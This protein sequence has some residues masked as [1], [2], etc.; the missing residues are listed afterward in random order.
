MFFWPF[1]DQWCVFFLEFNEQIP[2]RLS[3]HH[4]S[5]AIGSLQVEFTLQFKACQVPNR[6]HMQ[7]NLK[8]INW[9]HVKKCIGNSML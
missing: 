2:G 9:E 5:N 3:S 1:L 4:A 6:S 8:G 7:P